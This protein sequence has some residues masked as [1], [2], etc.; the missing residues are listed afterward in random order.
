MPS[1]EQF[2]KADRARPNQVAKRLVELLKLFGWL[3]VVG[4][5]GPAAHVAMMRK[6]VVSQRDWV[7]DDDFV[8][9]VGACAL[10]PGPNSTEM[11]M[12]IG[13]RR[14][15]WRGLFVCGAS[16]ILPAFFIVCVI[17]WI[18]QDVLTSAAIADMRRWL[19]PV[20]AA[21]VLDALW[22]L[23]TAAVRDLRD[24][25]ITALAVAAAVFGVAELAVLLLVGVASI[26]IRRTGG[27]RSSTTTNFSSVALAASIFGVLPATIPLWKIFFVFLQIGS[28]IYGSGYVLL[29]FLDSEVVDRGWI[30]TEVL[31]DAISVGQFTPGP[32]FT[33][34]TFIGWHLAGFAGAA[35]ATIGIFGPSF[36]FAALIDQVV[37]WSRRSH[38]FGAFLRGVSSGSIV[39]MATVL[40]RL[41]D[42]ALVDAWAVAT[43][44]VSL[45]AIL[46]V[47]QLRRLRNARRA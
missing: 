24:L 37:S 44:V 43:F 35:V 47:P 4:V 14:A 19:V 32:V 38:A 15:G 25:A 46:G 39:L 28:V 8:R 5:G 6:R 7:S 10:V 42:E 13:A 23:R 16:F 20:V 1:S 31:L 29:V 33:T 34:A 36:V 41:A 11:A 17:S 40:V 18:Y 22:K 9:M 26:V 30:S 2:G 27:H 45:S 21:I 3:G 12:A